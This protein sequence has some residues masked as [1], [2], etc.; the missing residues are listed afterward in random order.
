MWD[1]TL[2]KVPGEYNPGDLFTKAGLSQKR[3]E[4]LLKLFGCKYILGRPTIAPLLRPR[5]E[6]TKELGLNRSRWADAEDDNNQLYS[7]KE[8]ERYIEIKGLPHWNRKAH[9]PE[10]P[11]EAVAEIKEAKD[12]LTEHGQ[13]LARE[14]GGKSQLPWRAA[15]PSTQLPRR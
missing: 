5:K 15:Q 14:D 6:P 7:D 2:Y 3:I 4:N 9:A 10:K 1:F 12:E 8:L 13:K 11:R